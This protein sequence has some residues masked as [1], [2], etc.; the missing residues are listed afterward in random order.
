VHP[1]RGAAIAVIVAIAFGALPAEASAQSGSPGGATQATE[2]GITS[3]T[4]RIGV[5]ADVDNA[6]APGLFAGS[7]AAVKAFATFMNAHGGLAHRKLVVD[8]IDSHLSSSDARNA[9]IT[10]CSQDFAIVGTAA[11]FLQNVDDMLA[12]KD[13]AGATTGL[14]DLPIVS[15][16]LAQQCSSVSFGVNPGQIDCST[17]SLHPQTF[18]SNQG[19]IKYYLRTHK[20]LH[21]VMLYANDIKAAA[22]GGLVLAKGSEASGVKSDGEIGVSA[23]ATQSGYTPVA[24]RMKDKGSNYALNAGQFSQ[25]VALRKEAVLQGINN[26]DVVWDCFS[27]CY[28]KRLIEQG[29]SAVE[30]QYVTLTQIPLNETKYNKAVANYVKAAGADKVDGFGSYAWI[31][32]LLLRDSINAIVKKGGDNALTRKALL[33]QLT[34]TTSFNADGM[35]GTTNIGHRIPSPCFLVMQVKNGQFTR[36]YPTKPGTFDCKASN[37]ITEKADLFSG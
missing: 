13:L 18:R 33:A 19:T 32:S 16:E 3:S 36:V 10:A 24:Q 31:A 21:G 20:N 11:L 26:K 30:G 7:P 15:T 34:A 35:W 28:D 14:P 22:I 27:N 17:K 1:F 9:V 8:F 25:M 6:A 37:N 2:V 12:C 29:G 23:L 5:I 4:I